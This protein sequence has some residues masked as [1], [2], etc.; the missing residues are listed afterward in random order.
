VI[1]LT[2]L[3]RVTLQ[4]FVLAHLVLV[5]A[6]VL[7][8]TVRRRGERIIA[9]EQRA[10][11]VRREQQQLIRQAVTDERVR[12]A[13]ELHDLAAHA[14]G[15]I[16]IQAQAASRTMA[17]RPEQARS[18]LNAITTLSDEA[19][20]ELRRLLGFLRSEGDEL[21]ARRPQPTLD[22]L[23]PLAESF[24]QARLPVEIIIEGKRRQLPA[25]LE[26]SAYRVVQE[27]LTNTLKHAGRA[28]A[29][30]AIRYGSDTI[31]IEVTDT[32]RGPK[33]ESQAGQGL[34]GMRERV[35]VFGGEL[36][37]GAGSHGGFVLR[38]RLPVKQATAA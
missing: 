16:A 4:E 7:G 34:T 5:V 24:R 6:W 33:P 30:V 19:L 32:G 9:L 18:S 31:E 27:A 22:D 28:T 14:L 25:A 11:A 12:I 3:G 13:Q 26:T 35:T 37:Y 15:I 36:A 17:Q 29:L 23:E 38:A 8:D 2:L 1:P 10:A 20:N 21:E